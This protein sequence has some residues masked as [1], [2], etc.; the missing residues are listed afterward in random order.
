MIKKVGVLLS[1]ILLYSCHSTQ[2]INLKKLSE[3]ASIDIISVKPDTN[4]VDGLETQF[5]IELE[6]QFEDLEEALI[7]VG[8]N[9][10]KI[11]EYKMDPSQRIIVSKGSGRRIIKTTA[12]PRDWK[13]KGDFVLDVNLSP[14]SSKSDK[15]TFAFDT[16][17]LQFATPEQQEEAI[18]TILKQNKE[19]PIPKGSL[20]IVSITPESNLING[21]RTKFI[22]EVAYE[23]TGATKGEI[24]LGF[25][26]DQPD[27]FTMSP[28]WNKVIPSGKGHYKFKVTAIP[29]YWG[30]EG[31]FQVNVNLSSYPDYLERKVVAYD[32]RI[33]SFGND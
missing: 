8:F 24:T 29:K 19:V 20:S 26:T 2:S 13:E 5:T 22:V 10:Q 17:P 25:N 31:S 23:L 7:L 16:Y 14:L 30:Y 9:S 12:I 18:K 6:Y 33:L 11:L 1:L 3:S 27:I 28:H 21:K 4:L 15:G 32:K